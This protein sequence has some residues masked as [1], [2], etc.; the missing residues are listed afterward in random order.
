LAARLS[1]Y[2]VLLAFGVAGLARADTI[3]LKNGAVVEGTIVSEDDTQ[4]TVE[5][6]YASRTITMRQTVRRADIA[7]IIRLTKEEKA[8]RA[9]EKAFD[10]VQEYQLD[11]NTSEPLSYYDHVINDVFRPFLRL[12]PNSPHEQEVNKKIEAWTAERDKVASGLARLGNE[13]MPKDEAERRVELSR[14]QRLLDQGRAALTQSN[15]V[16]ALDQFKA[17]ISSSKRPEIATM[18]RRFY[19]ETCRLWLESLERQRQLLGDEIKMYEDRAT[20]TLQK[21]T[22]AELRLRA[23]SRTGG[24]SG[25]NTQDWAEE[26]AMAKLRTEYEH[27][28][29]EHAEASRHLSE[30]RLQL[31]GLDQSVTQAQA[32]GTTYPAGP[33]ESAPP[34]A[35]SATSPPPSSTETSTPSTEAS[36]PEAGAFSQVGDLVR[37]YWIVGVIV[38]VG[39]LWGLSRLTTRR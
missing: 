7:E 16:E 2:W 9:M 20:R 24:R 17:V 35:Q 27:A 38:L 1:L 31:A 25:T 33:A 14:A 11:P 30:L 19:S 34:A 36:S 3:R 29:S 10:Q 8:Q 15:F 26:T 18:A 21:R 37:R 6:D 39:G 23:A 4:V 13:W 28:Y 5:M 32:C 12:Y 22:D